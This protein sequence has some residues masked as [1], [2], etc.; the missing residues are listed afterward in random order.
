MTLEVYMP[1]ARTYLF[2]EQLIKRY[3]DL[4]STS[5]YREETYSKFA[6]PAKFSIL[7]DIS[8]DFGTRPAAFN[9]DFEKELLDLRTNLKGYFDSQ[10]F[11][12]IAKH[13]FKKKYNEFSE[14]D[15][16]AD[17]ENFFLWG[18][19][20]AIELG[21]SID[22][23]IEYERNKDSF[24]F[25]AYRVIN[26]RSEEIFIILG[27]FTD[28]NELD[29]LFLF[30]SSKNDRR[31]SI[32]QIYESVV[33]SDPFS[34]SD[35]EI[36]FNA[37]DVISDDTFRTKRFSS[38]VVLNSLQKVGMVRTSSFYNFYTSDESTPGE[39]DSV[40]NSSNYYELA[41]SYRFMPRHIKVSWNPMRGGSGIDTRIVPVS[42]NISDISEIQVLNELYFSQTFR[43]DVKKSSSRGLSMGVSTGTS[44]SDLYVTICSSSEEKFKNSRF[45]NLIAS[46]FL[47]K[48]TKDLID[49]KIFITE[50][51]QLRNRTDEQPLLKYVGYLIHKYEHVSGNS[52]KLKEVIMLDDC[53][54]SCYYDFNVLY[55]KKYRYKIASL[56]KWVYSTSLTEVEA[57]YSD[58]PEI[59]PISAGTIIAPTTIIA[60]TSS[61]DSTTI[62]TP[63]LSIMGSIEAYE[64]RLET[65]IGEST[66]ESELTRVESIDPLETL[67][68]SITSTLTSTTTT[69]LSGRRLL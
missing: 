29:D 46:P 23:F 24:L 30:L 45:W 13:C 1:I 40:A 6:I 67:I 18:K 35:E 42:G 28:W 25:Q 19:N 36:A 14:T 44:M 37:S 47:Q 34:T 5:L 41:S 57:F 2:A 38:Y 54:S 22:W 11:F 10:M 55:N 58:A 49:N 60:A 52:W 27:S 64:G 33:S 62:T 9:S 12:I 61:L 8:P 65:L 63:S 4:W 50:H 32:K 59:H 51:D 17:I 53:T 68:E 56:I 3:V 43:K 48:E 21:N 20:K 15:F 26:S 16:R 39:G 31:P 7:I 69:R 66:R